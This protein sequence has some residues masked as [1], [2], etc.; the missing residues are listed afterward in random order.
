MNVINL[1]LSDQRCIDPEFCNE[2]R[3]NVS[4]FRSVTIV[5]SIRRF[6]VLIKT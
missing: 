2:C 5:G 3:I 4:K 1:F 6:I